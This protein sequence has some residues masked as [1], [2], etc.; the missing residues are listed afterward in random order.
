MREKL[1]WVNPGVELIERRN[2]W[3]GISYGQRAKIAKVMGNG[4]F[5][6]DGS[7][8]QWRPFSDGT[9]IRTGD[10]RREVHFVV[11]SPELEDEIAHAKRLSAARRILADE[12][13]RLDGLSRLRAGDND[14]ELLAS[15]DRISALKSEAQS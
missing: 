12:A 3:T 5:K 15:A 11:V 1:D 10:S 6:V 8:Q 2:G 4:N 14:D 7:D 9:A 13:K